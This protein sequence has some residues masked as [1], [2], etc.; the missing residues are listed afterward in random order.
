[1]KRLF[2]LIVC[3]VCAVL[4][5]CGAQRETNLS[6]D[7]LSAFRQARE[8]EA[9]STVVW[10]N[11]RI[12]DLLQPSESIV[13]SDSFADLNN[14]LHEG[15]GELTQPEANLMQL[16]CLGSQQGGAGCMAF[17]R[18]LLPDSV[19][20]D[21]ELKILSTN[22]LL[23]AFVGFQGREGQ[24]M[25]ADLPSRTGVFADYIS[26]SD[27]RGYHVSVSRYDDDGT[28]TGVSNW[29]RNPAHFL[30]H[31]Q[32]DVC[33]EPNRW[34]ALRIVKRGPLLQ[35]AVDG[36]LVGGF[37]D[38]QDIPDELPGAGYFGFRTI[39]SE[40]RAQ[41]RDFRVNRLQSDF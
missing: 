5:H 34:Y 1:M 13:T 33:R 17:Y 6:A 18:Q 40:V 31:Q 16:N 21:F 26:N 38:P 8:N 28:H 24:D 32:P 11:P 27:L 39:G 12:P 14:W 37:V 25:F 2:L 41:I 29:R 9:D 15:I 10:G 3:G 30:M 7:E 35:M 19:A 36:E 22:G 4:P 20:I 23:I